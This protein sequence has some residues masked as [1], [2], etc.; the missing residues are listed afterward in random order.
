MNT[1]DFRFY[2]V[3]KN[4]DANPY[5][6]RGVIAVADGLGGS[7]SAVHML[8]PEQYETLRQ[9]LY[10]TVL[11]WD[12][13]RD[14]PSQCSYFKDLFDPMTDGKPDTSALW[15]SRIVMARFAYAV[16]KGRGALGDLSDPQVRHRLARF[17][18]DG[19]RAV[20][21]EFRLEKGRLDS[22]ILLPTTFAAVFLR[23]EEGA[24]TAETVWAGDSR[25]YALTGAG[26]KLLSVDD[27][28]ATGAITN[29]FCVGKKPAVLHYSRFRLQTPCA[30]LA[31]SD[32]VFD[33]YAGHEH[34]CVEHVFL[35]AMQQSATIDELRRCLYEHYM[36]I[37]ADDATMAFR[38]VGFPSYEAM[39]QFFAPRAVA[40]TQMYDRLV[41]F[42]LPLEVESY[43]EDDVCGYIRSRTSDKFEAVVA[44]ACAVLRAGGDD[45]ACVPSIRRA[46]E[47]AYSRR[48]E[49]A[50]SARRLR[51]DRLL[52]KLRAR[53]HTDYASARL[54]FVRGKKLFRIGKKCLYDAHRVIELANSLCGAREWCRV[55]A[56]EQERIRGE[57]E[58]CQTAALERADRHYDAYRSSRADPAR[59]EDSAREYGACRYIAEAIDFGKAPENVTPGA[60]DVCIVRSVLQKRE[61][62]RAACAALNAAE[63]KAKQRGEAY[64]CAVREFFQKYA[65][66]IADDPS[67]FFRHELLKVVE[68]EE[69]PRVCEPEER[70]IL[71]DVLSALLPVK[72]EVVDE[73]VASMASA[74][75][76][77]SAVDTFY[78]GTRLSVFRLFYTM[79]GEAGGEREAFRGEL[80][81]FEGEYESLLGTPSVPAAPPA[82]TKSTDA[83]YACAPAVPTGGETPAE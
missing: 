8:R 63:E 2:S 61:E 15:A 60:E 9:A 39:K 59:R 72:R 1:L 69:L 20:A 19:L 11:P 74:P 41:R 33:P 82:E 62:W 23:E 40:V 65:E 32:G 58:R 29:L 36:N 10:Q 76:R 22:Q 7:G 21:S 27:E 38:A 6:G 53:F 13:W 26:L 79:Q 52:D 12:D 46:Y 70:I 71:Q 3:L 25:C 18:E 17:L 83:A 5:V 34:L 31:C 47:T 49:E 42:R 50:D 37:H 64:D 66:A 24:V 57:S 45:L 30:V 55:K 75:S 28:D 54:F 51:R 48:K 67:A 78:N 44:A 4:E 77:S 35:R 81:A 16:T 43:S 73:I 80:T 68:A 14:D 56:E